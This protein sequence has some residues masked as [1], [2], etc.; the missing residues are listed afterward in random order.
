M[1]ANRS[2]PRKRYT[3]KAHTHTHT[4]SRF[5]SNNEVF[6]FCF[7]CSR[8]T[9]IH[10]EKKH[11]LAFIGYSLFFRLK[12]MLLL[13]ILFFAAPFIHRMIVFLSVHPL[14]CKSIIGL[15]PFRWNICVRPFFIGFYFVYALE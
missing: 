6:V 15:T 4:N 1:K 8:A 12:P 2:R 14:C 5:N 3:C 7:L 13:F 10:T 11:T 9:D